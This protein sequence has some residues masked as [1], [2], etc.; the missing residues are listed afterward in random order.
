MPMDKPSKYKIL[1]S[2]EALADMKETKKYILA[3]FK[4]REYAENFSRKIK[5]AIKELSVFPTGYEST[6]YVIE[7][8]EVYFKPHSTYLIFFVIEDKTVTVIRVLKDRMY[9][10]SI[11]K[12]MQKIKTVRPLYPDSLQSAGGFCG[13]FLLFFP[14]HQAVASSNCEL[15]SE[16]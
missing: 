10:Q 11:I 2:K 8:L 5:K 12:K 13:R 14:F 15:Y 4:Y 1:L 16:A 9:W 3:T 7:S 6:G